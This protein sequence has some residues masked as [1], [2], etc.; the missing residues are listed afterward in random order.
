MRYNQK[1]II[2]VFGIQALARKKLHLLERSWRSQFAGA[3]G[4]RAP[5]VAR[6]HLLQ[7]NNNT[8]FEL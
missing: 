6:S 1:R 4:P 5:P 2:L 3:S 7:D 8:K